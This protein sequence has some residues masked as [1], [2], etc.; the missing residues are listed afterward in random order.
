MYDPNST[1][2]GRSVRRTL[3]ALALLLL[4][5]ALPSL[6]VA[7]I[8]SNP[9]QWYINNQIYSTRVFNG[10]VADSMI[11]S[12]TAKRAAGTGGGTAGAG[13]AAAP[14]PV[15]DFTRFAATAGNLVPATLATR[16]GGGPAA[17]RAAQDRYDGYI[18]MYVRTAAKDRF[19]A[20]DLA[21]AY[22]YYVVNNW[23]ILNDLVDVPSEQDPRLR[24][25]RDGFERIERAAL[26]RQQQISPLQER[27]IYQQFRE[28]LA[29][30]AEVQ[31]MTDAQK[32]E[33]AEMLAISLGVNWASYMAGLERGDDALAQQAR[34]AA[35]AGLEKLLGRPIA[36]ISIDERGVVLR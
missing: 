17:R 27:A 18:D 22:E 2:C 1:R 31:K 7:Q 33:A 9:A 24:G 5:G 34:D 23:H 32:Q 16:E 13:S 8:M 20:D 6:A 11:T 3:P 36:R 19:P 10:A 30:A 35:R 14:V 26:K 15:R 4:G 12:S 25:A 29:G 28:R 21:Y